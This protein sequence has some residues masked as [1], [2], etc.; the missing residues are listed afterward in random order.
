M[1]D[2]ILI[3]GGNS[4]IAK[5]CVSLFYRKGFSITL[6]GR[7]IDE[8]TSYCKEHEI[9]ATIIYFDALD[10][11]SHNSFYEKLA[12]KPT[13]V[14]C[15]FG[16]LT[17]NLNS[18]KNFNEA[19]KTID[20]NFKGSVSIL[21]IIAQDFQQKKAGNIIGISS[22]AADRGR[23]SNL[24]Y[25]ASKAGFESYLSGL[26]NMMSPYNVKVIT[27]KPGFVKTKMLAGLETSPLLT[28]TPEQVAKKI[29]KSYKQK[30][31]IVYG[32]AKWRIIMIII[33]AIP[34]RIFKNLNL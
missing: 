11:E 23:A 13:V 20:T 33:K 15:A 2:N 5:A 21:N 7:N 17:E 22:V 19:E 30:R 26:R 31:N 24:I 14:L 6:A 8:I 1:S 4:D 32:D 28:S 34:E 3:L 29:Y 25:C 27:V 12:I 16:Y 10:Y 9:E 18:Y